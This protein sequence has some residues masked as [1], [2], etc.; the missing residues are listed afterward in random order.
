M[1][2]T[3]RVS[4]LAIVSEKQLHAI[5]CVL[6]LSL[7]MLL[8][9]SSS[10]EENSASMSDRAQT[11][12]RGPVKSCREESTYRNMTDAA[13]KALEVRFEH[14][15][16]YDTD[17]RI[18]STQ[19]RNSD[20]TE[21]VRR[22]TYS[23]SAHL[24]KIASGIT[25]Q[26]LTETFYSYDQEGRL[27]KIATAGRSETP[28]VFRYDER[29]R[30]TKMQTSRASD[31]RPNSATGGS[32]FE[33]LDMAPNLPDG[34]TTTTIYNE[35][36]RPTEVQV[37]DANG[38]LVNHALRRYDA[39][40]HV[41]EEKQIYDNLLVTMFPP[42]AR[43]KLLDESGLSTDQLRQELHAQ[44]TE[45]TK[46]QAG[47]YSVSY[48]YDSGGRLIHTSRRIF[49]QEDEIDTTYNEH[50]DTES[51]MTR[52]TRPETENELTAPGL[53]SYSEMRYSYQYDEHGNWREKTVSYRSNSDAAFQSSSV[54]KR[55][56]AYYSPIGNGMHPNPPNG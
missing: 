16:V 9:Q 49:N 4:R 40:G 27:E 22:Y 52:S 21:W 43:Q 41:S 13:G 25:G 35:H 30:K 39:Q 54:I 5:L 23:N 20:G 37:R 28:V 56:L 47:H 44:L 48:R 19:S 53:P 18:L 12:I 3:W 42:E 45:F 14:T 8:A 26:A 2:L 10:P 36:D 24:L 6:L 33:A 32:P 17:G 55:S 1:Q 31:Y 46:G 51:E 29:G 34:G 11:G 15:T 50:G 7:P 38:E